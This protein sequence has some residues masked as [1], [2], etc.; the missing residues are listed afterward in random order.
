MA[1][2]WAGRN[3]KKEAPIPGIPPKIA[4][5]DVDD[6]SSCVCNLKVEVD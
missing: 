4:L 3:L 6:R 5:Q 1:R 2:W